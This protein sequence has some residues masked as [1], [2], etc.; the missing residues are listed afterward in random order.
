MATFQD[1]SEKAPNEL[2]TWV[3]GRFNGLGWTLLFTPPYLCNF[4]PIEMYWAF[5]KNSIGREYFKGR[6]MDWIA[7]E[8]GQLGNHID[9]GY[10]IRNVW[11]ID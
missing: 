1:F 10:L 2:L 6:T 7:T 4:Y 11:T 3:E 5:I 9:C 8:F